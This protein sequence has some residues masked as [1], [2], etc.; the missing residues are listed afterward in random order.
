MKKLLLSL[1][2]LTGIA[3]VATAQ[4][5]RFGLKA[6]VG[7]S[8]VRGT[9]AGDGYKNL[10]GVNAGLMADFGFSERFSFHPELLYSQR[11]TK[12]DNTTTYNNSAGTLTLTENGK[13]R[14]HY[15]DLPLLLRLKASGFFLEAGP[16]LGYLLA[17]KSELTT[18]GI[19]TY[20]GG[21]TPTIITRTDTDDSTDGMRRLD[22]GYLIGIGYQL[23]Q[24][25]EVGV[26]FNNGFSNSNFDR[27]SSDKVHNSVF[28]FQ[29]GYLFGGK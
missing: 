17:Q 14:L 9:D 24:G 7:L 5:A 2:L 10:F 27:S 22:V 20:N 23:P 16:Q 15:L 28:Q 1:G 3:N 26:R 4:E 18:T 25:F 8:N 13:G 11:G 21:T 6:G 12:V 29:V 19:T